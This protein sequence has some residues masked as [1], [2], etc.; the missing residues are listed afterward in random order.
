MFPG[1]PHSVL[2]IIHG[3]KE[4]P[5]KVKGHVYTVCSNQSL[6]HIVIVSCSKRV[7]LNFNKLYN[8]QAKDILASPPLSLEWQ[9]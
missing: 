6:L 5:T 9:C 4:Q 1:L 2:T 8:A 7:S 3:S